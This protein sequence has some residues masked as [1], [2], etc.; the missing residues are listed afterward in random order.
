MVQIFRNRYLTG[1]CVHNISQRAPVATS[2][3]RIPLFEC[4]SN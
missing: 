2:F 4:A 3:A 1:R